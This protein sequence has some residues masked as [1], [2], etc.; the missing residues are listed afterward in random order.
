MRLF[1]FVVRRMSQ[2]VPVRRVC[3]NQTPIM[4]GACALPFMRA[5][6]L[7]ESNPERQWLV[8]PLWARAGVGIVGGA[9][10][11][12]KSWLGLDLALSVATTM[13]F[14]TTLLPAIHWTFLPDRVANLLGVAVPAF[15]SYFGHKFYTYR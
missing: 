8:E 12:C 10:K 5:A 11:S 14:A 3:R 15:S 7:G 6:S 1:L 4:N 2:I 13:A 9:P